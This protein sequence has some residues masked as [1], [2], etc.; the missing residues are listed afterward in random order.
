ML[1]SYYTNTPKT[2]GVQPNTKG[3]CCAQQIATRIALACY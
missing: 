3:S 2:K 1:L